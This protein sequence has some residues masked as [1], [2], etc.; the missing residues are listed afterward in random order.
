[1]GREAEREVK[2]LCLIFCIL[3]FL[4]LTGAGMPQREHKPDYRF[5]SSETM[6]TLEDSSRWKTDSEW[7]QQLR[8]SLKKHSDRDARWVYIFQQ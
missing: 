3:I 5:I 1:M 8:K 4:V 2:T 7:N 6:Y